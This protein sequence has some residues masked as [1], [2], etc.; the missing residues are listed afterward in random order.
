MLIICFI[1][2]RWSAKT[3]TIM[4]RETN[5]L[6][7]EY[8]S[9]VACPS[10]ADKIWRYTNTD[11]MLCSN[12]SCFN[13]KYKMTFDNNPKTDVNAKISILEITNFTEEDVREYTCSCKFVSFT[14]TLEVTN[15]ISKY[16]YI[17]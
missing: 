11:K 17:K 13:E 9:D 12:G 15:Y 8:H 16:L 2:V 3:D 1:T 5:S 6:I 14:K 7:C 10:N 4:L